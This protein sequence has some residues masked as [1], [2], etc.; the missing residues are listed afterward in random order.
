VRSLD[1]LIAEAEDETEKEMAT[2][3]LAHLYRLLQS[4]NTASVQGAALV[5][6]RGI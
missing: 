3:A 1:Q 5:A 6:R 4:Q 2:R